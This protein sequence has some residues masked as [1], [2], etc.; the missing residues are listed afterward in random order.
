M[1]RRDFLGGMSAIFA[2]GLMP[3][4]AEAAGPPP[5]APDEVEPWLAKLD[6]DLQRMSKQAPTE[7]VSEALDEA[8]LPPTLMG[9]TFATLSW[10]TAWRDSDEDIRQHPA[11]Q[12]RLFRAAD[13]LARRAVV[14]AAWIEGVDR[15][16][17]RAIGALLGRPNRL[18][19]VLDHVLIH[20]GERMNPARRR[21]LRGTL[22]DIARATR[23]A[24]A[25]P[26]AFLDELV[27]YVDH[28]AREEG[29]DRHALAA[30]SSAAAAQT[31]EA[32]TKTPI[33]DRWQMD[34]PPEKIRLGLRLMGLAVL[35]SAG[36]LL[37]FAIS[38]SIF[39]APLTF[40]TLLTGFACFIVGP[41]LLV[42]GLLLLITG[43]MER[44]RE[45]RERK[46][47]ALLYLLDTEDPLSPLPA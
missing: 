1:D 3:D 22:G 16:R 17:R 21:A 33:K 31:T 23:A 47:K 20:K 11:F 40:F 14:M 32:H 10:F 36:G 12:E 44:R 41:I 26:E 24:G 13:V 34:T 29:V 43:R 15:A 35:I 25:K 28:A 42:A 45:R 2:A 5:T 19:A 39:S 7:G 4:E 8:G 6:Q 18:M 46:D 27:L 37:I 38:V 9:E 30:E